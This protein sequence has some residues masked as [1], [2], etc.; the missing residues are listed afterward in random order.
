M[1]FS[2]LECSLYGH[3]LLLYLALLASHH[4]QNQ[5]NILS[6]LLMDRRDELR[7]EF[8]YWQIPKVLSVVIF[9]LLALIL[10]AWLR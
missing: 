9:G 1:V 5:V 2:I 8:D 4:R 6:I 7:V 10:F 3:L